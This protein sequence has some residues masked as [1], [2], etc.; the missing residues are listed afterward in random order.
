M[1]LP[2]TRPLPPQI[3][4][5]PKVSLPRLPLLLLRPQTL[6]EGQLPLPPLKLHLPPSLS[7]SP[8]PPHHHHYHHP[9]PLFVVMGMAACGGPD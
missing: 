3:L 5:P 7:A 2:L 1:Q 9:L 8:L 4:L 6:I